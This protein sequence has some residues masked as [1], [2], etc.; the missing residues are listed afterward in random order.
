MAKR[1]HMTVFYG[2]V[3]Q[4]PTKT[5]GTSAVGKFFI[6]SIFFG[7]IGRYRKTRIS[8]S[9]YLTKVYI[10]AESIQNIDTF[11]LENLV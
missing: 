11:K 8:A 4:A 10:G 2:T 3:H 5:A 9:A 6:L 7:C 1:R